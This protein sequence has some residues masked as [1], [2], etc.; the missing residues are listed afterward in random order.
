MHAQT[1]LAER[2]M[3]QSPWFDTN[4]AAEYLGASPK[5]LAIWRCRGEGPEY[6]IVNKRLVR[7]HVDGLDAFVRG[8]SAR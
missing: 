7:Y 2:P 1:T 8:E 4:A 6:H 3:F 5:T